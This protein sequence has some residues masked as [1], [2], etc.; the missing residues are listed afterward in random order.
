MSYT[1]RRIS[2]E[3]KFEG[4]VFSVR[5]DVAQ[6]HNGKRVPREVVEHSGG[7]VVVPVTEKR[8]V[9]A[10]RQYRYPVARELLEV[11]AGRLEP[12]ENRADAARRELSEE[13]GCRAEELLYLG[14]IYPSPG[15]CEETLHIYLATGLKRGEAHPD[16]DEFLTAETIPLR[17]MADMIARNEIKDAK[18]IAGIHLVLAHLDKQ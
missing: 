10:V 14:E 11:P 8:E 13:T 2:G 4:K 17:E 1:E 12:G 9:V 16:E 6:L 15:F 3:T 5:R 7:V 18:T